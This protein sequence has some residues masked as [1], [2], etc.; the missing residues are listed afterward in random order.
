MRCLKDWTYLKLILPMGFIPLSLSNHI[1]Q[2]INLKGTGTTPPRS[3][4]SC[5][6]TTLNTS[7][8]S[9]SQQQEARI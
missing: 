4:N 3:E 8:A 2:V 6:A 5:I 9:I 1:R 7:I